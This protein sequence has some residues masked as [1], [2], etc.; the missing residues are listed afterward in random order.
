MALRYF[1]SFMSVVCKMDFHVPKDVW[2]VLR[3]VLSKLRVTV[4]E[5]EFCAPKGA[6]QRFIFVL[7]ERNAVFEG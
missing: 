6:W 4:C 7:C 1:S 3:F 2:P 5:M